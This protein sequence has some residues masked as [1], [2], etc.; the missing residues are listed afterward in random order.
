MACSSS[1]VCCI[2]LDIGKVSYFEA[3]LTLIVAEGNQADKKC[4]KKLRIGIMHINQ[5]KLA[6]DLIINLL[7]FFKKIG[8]RAS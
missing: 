3:D 7:F 1:R 8:R 5:V 4:R 6:L 2:L